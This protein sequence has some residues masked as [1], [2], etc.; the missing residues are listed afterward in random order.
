MEGGDR[1]G[2]TTQ[3]FILSHVLEKNGIA[4]VSLRFPNRETS[5][6]KAID[7]HLN[8][9]E[10]V[11][12]E[13]LRV[14]MIENRREMIGKIT[15]AIESGTHVIIDRYCHSGA[16]YGEATTGKPV[17][18]CLHEERGIPRPDIVLYFDLDPMVASKRSGFGN[19]S[20]ESVELQMKVRDAYRSMISE[21]WIVVDANRYEKT[22]H[23]EIISHVLHAIES[24]LGYS[25]L[26]S[27]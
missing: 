4:A 24:D 22:I 26:S 8:G 10:K 6:G 23:D 11:S 27:M 5:I 12:A 3:H 1:S 2:K 20:M 17:H 14:M 18:D 16:A 7:A 13:S 9:K 19:E 15:E 21:N 25:P